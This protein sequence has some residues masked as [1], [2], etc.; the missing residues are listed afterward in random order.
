MPSSCEHPMM[1]LTAATDRAPSC[2]MNRTIASL[3][4]GSVLASKGDIE[5]LLFEPGVIVSYE[6][7]RSWC[8][9]FGAGSARRV[10]AVRRK[11]GTTWHL[12]EVFVTLR[13]KPYPKE[14]LIRMGIAIVLHYY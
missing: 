12:D 13:G 8:G 6:S 11:P 4:C 2:S 1:R 3:I 9:K 5:E 10:K 14:T 7:I